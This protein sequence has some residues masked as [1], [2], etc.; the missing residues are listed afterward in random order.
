MTETIGV[1]TPLVAVGNKGQIP[2]AR[3]LLAGGN[4]CFTQLGSDLYGRV[5]VN[6]APWPGCAPGGAVSFLCLAKEK[7]PKERPPPLP[8]PRRYRAVE[9]AVLASGGV[10]LNSLRSNN[11]S[12]LPPEAALLGAARGGPRG[13]G[14]AAQSTPSRLGRE[15]GSVCQPCAVQILESPTLPPFRDRRDARLHRA[16]PAPQ[17]P[18]LYAPRS[19]VECGS[20]LALSERSEFSQ[21]PHATSTAGSPARK[22][23]GADSW[24]AFLLVTFLLRKR[25][26]TA[27]PGASPGRRS[28]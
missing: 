22:R 7:A 15:A 21:T 4:R 11:A 6:G 19:T 3:G 28:T 25:K 2:I 1:R 20:G 17:G 24:G 5:G 9:P 14:S 8:A 23:W 26:V 16:N 27:P 18:H 10:W 12:P 13:T